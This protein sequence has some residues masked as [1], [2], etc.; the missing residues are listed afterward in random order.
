MSNATQSRSETFNRMAKAKR[1]AEVLDWTT[2]DA[3][4]ATESEW[5]QARLFAHVSAPS[6]ETRAA[7][8][9]LMDVA[10]GATQRRLEEASGSEHIAY[11]T[12]RKAAIIAMSFEAA[13]L[14]DLNEATEEQWEIANKISA[15]LTG[16]TST[17]TLNRVSDSVRDAVAALLA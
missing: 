4:I 5:H 10:A 13:G 17:K 3:R 15:R 11:R 1:L 8:T 6:A 7:V 9:A 2:A 12:A 16:V 14:D